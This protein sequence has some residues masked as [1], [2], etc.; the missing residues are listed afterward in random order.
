[1]KISDAITSCG[2]VRGKVVHEPK[3]KLFQMCLELNVEFEVLIKN[4]NILKINTEL[5]FR[6]AKQKKKRTDRKRKM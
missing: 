4:L 1:M 3:T 6:E 5:S 2:D